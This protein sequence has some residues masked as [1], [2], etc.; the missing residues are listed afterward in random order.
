MDTNDYFGAQPPEIQNNPQPPQ[1]EI[2]EAGAC[3]SNQFSDPPAAPRP[4]ADEPTPYF[5]PAQET[6]KQP[7]P[8]LN[9]GEQPLHTAPPRYNV[10]PQAHAAKEKKKKEKTV[11]QQLTSFGVVMVVLC[12][13]LSFI[14]GAGGAFAVMSFFPTGRVKSQNDP[15]EITEGNVHEI[16]VPSTETP[17]D[18]TAAT[19][20]STQPQ[21]TTTAPAA[22]E[23]R[24]QET[25]ASVPAAATKSKGDI[26]AEAVNS[27]VGIRAVS[28]RQVATFFGR[29]TTQTV[30]SSG[31]GFF[32]TADG[33]VVTNYHVIEGAT[34]IT[35]STY[36]G[37]AYAATVRGYEEANDIAVLK[38][39]GSFT[40]SKLGRSSDLRVGDDILVIGNPL[41]NLSYTFTDGVVSY[42]NRMI[43]GDTGATINMFQTNAAI[44]EGNSGGP[45]Y[46]MNGEVVGIASAKYAS[47][48][49]EGLGFCIPI[50]DVNGMIDDIIR[51]GYVTGKPVLGVSVQTVSSAMAARYNISIGCYVVALGEGSAADIAGIQT[52]DVITAI[53]DTVIYSANDMGSALS[54]KTAGDSVTV[55]VNRSG[56][57]MVF[58]VTLDEYKPGAARTDYSNVYDF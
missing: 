20:P 48:S 47:S 28:E 11:K 10:P 54:G 22:S 45:V 26:Y 8:N 42:L 19:E 56:T 32:I 15:T 34:E 31:S 36:D 23:N 46:N 51:T 55:R 2:P 24:P 37:S 16:T 52:A 6:D 25:T 29:Y 57:S 13:L 53:D 49:I 58:T 14:A 18:Q 38:I 30:T 50:D 33:Y 7:A 40:P 43:T 12:F 41:G 44:N 39:D 4:A 27:V 35:V 3:R 17:S 1:T 21:Q 9:R 5:G